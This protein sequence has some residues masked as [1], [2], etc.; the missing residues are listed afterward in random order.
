MNVVRQLATAQAKIRAMV[1]G[2]KK[3]VVDTAPQP[4]RA[5]ELRRVSGGTGEGTP[6]KGW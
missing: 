2:K 1:G 6:V 4:L 3:T 5:D